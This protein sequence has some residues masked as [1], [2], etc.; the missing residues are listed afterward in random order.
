MNVEGWP[1][2][3]ARQG[4]SRP[5]VSFGRMRDRVSDRTTVKG[6]GAVSTRSVG[7]IL[8]RSSF[9]LTLQWWSGRSRHSR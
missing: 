4:R 1:A 7:I 5:F 6:R 8:P 9:I 3:T 2:R